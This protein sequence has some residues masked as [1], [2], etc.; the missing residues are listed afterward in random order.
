MGGECI[1]LDIKPSVPVNK[2]EETV[3]LTDFFFLCCVIKKNGVK[4]EIG[5]MRAASFRRISEAL[6]LK[7]GKAGARGLPRTCCLPFSGCSC[8]AR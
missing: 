3:L 4:F 6:Y 5:T 2:F 8:H 1:F 7:V